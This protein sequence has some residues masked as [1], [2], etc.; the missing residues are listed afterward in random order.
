VAIGVAVLTFAFVWAGHAPPEVRSDWDFY[1]LGARGII[2]G[3][4]PYRAVE[5]AM[6]RGEVKLPLFYPATAPLLLAPLGALSSR[7]G[8]S[9]FSAGGMLAL[10]LSARQ[11]WQWGM[12]LSAPAFNAVLLGQ[13]SPLLVAAVGLPALTVVWAAKPTVGLALFAGWPSRRAVLSGIALTVLSLVLFPSWPWDWRDA[14]AGS[15][16][17]LAPIQRPGGF[18]LLL[19]LLRWREPEGRL[20]SVLALVPHTT[21]LHDMLS[22]LLAARTGR[23]LAVLVT[24]GYVFAALANNFTPRGPDIVPQ[25]LAAQWPIALSL[26]Y[27]PALVL[28]LRRPLAGGA[29]RP[30]QPREAA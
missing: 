13:W 16:N 25:M 18:L 11:R 2:H 9:L 23:E 12:L 17:Y 5:A 29:D 19:G 3:I 4:N 20:L 21:A 22:P 10:A 14:V 27:I 28:V 7:L 30:S 8:V 6:Q 26:I 1:Y 15:P 24:L